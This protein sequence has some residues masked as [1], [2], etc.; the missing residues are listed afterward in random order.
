MDLNQCAC[1]GK[2]LAR[3]LR[4]AVLALLVR[5]KT[6][7][8]DIVQQLHGLEIFAGFPPDTS[9]VYKVLKSMEREGLVSA[10]WEFGGSGPAKRRYAL[11]RSGTACLKRWART[12]EGYRAQI[13]GLL[14]IVKPHGKSLTS[15]RARK[16]KCRKG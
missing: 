6:H 4:P 3:L 12:L 8:Y 11:T 7:G 16:C 10:S 14:G 15:G 2:T 13:D 5:E 9:G 1:S